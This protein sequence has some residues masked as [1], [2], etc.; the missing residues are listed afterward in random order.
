MYQIKYRL[1]KM[2][3]TILSYSQSID[4]TIYHDTIQSPSID[5]HI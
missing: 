2:N 5:T 4:T 3:D 1:T